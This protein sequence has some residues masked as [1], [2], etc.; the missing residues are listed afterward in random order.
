MR[1]WIKETWRVWVR[2]WTGWLI[3]NLMLLT[4][5]VWTMCAFRLWDSLVRW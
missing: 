4:V 2:Y 5:V 1:E 3:V